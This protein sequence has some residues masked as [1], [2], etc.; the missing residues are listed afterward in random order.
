[1]SQCLMLAGKLLHAILA[2]QAQASV[3]GF[4]NARRLDGLAHRHELYDFRRAPGA[5][6][7]GSNAGADALDI[8]ANTHRRPKIIAWSLELAVWSC[9]P[10]ACGQSDTRKMPAAESRGSQC[11]WRPPRSAL[12]NG[13]AHSPAANCEIR[14]ASARFPAAQLCRRRRSVRWRRA[15]RG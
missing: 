2:E 8:F 6:R 9:L 7:G 12:W 5:L 10:A 15:S 13:P 11:Y 3:I 4:D 14:L 1:M